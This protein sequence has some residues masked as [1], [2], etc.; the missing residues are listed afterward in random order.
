MVLP[1]FTRTSLMYSKGLSEGHSNDQHCKPPP[2]KEE[3]KKFCYKFLVY[4]A[5]NLRSV[6]SHVSQEK[7]QASEYKVFTK[8]L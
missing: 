1:C 5:K 2:F 6:A 7:P 3:E 8:S 4:Q